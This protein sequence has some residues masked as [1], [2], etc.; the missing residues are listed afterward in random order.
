[1]PARTRPSR[2]ASAAVARAASGRGR[3]P[4]HEVGLLIEEAPVASRRGGKAWSVAAGSRQARAASDAHSSRVDARGRPRFGTA[5]SRRRLRRL[6]HE[7]HVDVSPRYAPIL[8][9]AVGGLGSGGRCVCLSTIL[10]RSYAPT[11]D[12]CPARFAPRDHDG[13]PAA[14]A[15]IHEPPTASAARR[16]RPRAMPSRLRRLDPCATD[17]TPAPSADSRDHPRRSPPGSFSQSKAAP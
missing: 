13:M 11:R 5:R 17:G 16:V 14:A 8:L 9:C 10:S 1:M 2:G 15:E 7:N 12:G 4:A 6:S 3:I